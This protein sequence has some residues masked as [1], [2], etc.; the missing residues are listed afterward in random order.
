[1]SIY[2]MESCFFNISISKKYATNNASEPK[3]ATKPTFH[4][5]LISA[6]RLVQSVYILIPYLPFLNQIWP[7]FDLR[8]GPGPAGDLKFRPENV[9]LGTNGVRKPPFGLKLCV[10]R[11]TPLMTPLDSLKGPKRPKMGPLGFRV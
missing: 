9:N 4:I 1:M 7:A 10:V 2:L 6:C 8:A 5:W 3:N 11:A